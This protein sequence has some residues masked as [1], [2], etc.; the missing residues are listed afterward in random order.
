MKRAS[1]SGL[2]VLKITFMRERAAG[3]DGVAVEAAALVYGLVEQGGFAFVEGGDFC[4]AAL[5][6][7]P[8]EYEPCDVDGVGAGGVVHAVAV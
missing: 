7:Q 6:L 5:G 4:H 2:P 8:A 1:S 3:G